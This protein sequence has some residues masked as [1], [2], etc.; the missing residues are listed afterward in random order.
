MRALSD[1]SLL[2]LG[3]RLDEWDFRVLFRGLMNLPGQERRKRYEHVLA[4]IDPEESTT[5][6]PERA[7][8]YMEEYVVHDNVDVY[9]GTVEDFTRELWNRWQRERSMSPPRPAARQGNPFVG[10]RPLAEEALY[11]RDREI[12]RLLD[13]LIADRIVLLYSPSGAGKTSLIQAGLVPRLR[14]DGFTVPPL[15]PVRVGL[16]PRA[17]TPLPPHNRYQLSV[18]LSL[19][20]VLPAK[21]QRSPA[22]LAEMSLKRY[23]QAWPGR[24]GEGRNLVLL[25]D[26]FEELCA[27][28]TTDLSAKAEFMTRLGSVLR[29]PSLWALFAMREE[30]VTMLDPYLARFP[31]RLSSTF[32][33]DFLD[34]QA[35]RVAIQRPVADLGRGITFSDG[36]ATRLV[37]DLRRVRVDRPDGSTRVLG[38]WVEPVQLQVVCRQLWEELPDIDVIDEEHIGAAEDIDKALSRYYEK[39][40]RTVVAKTG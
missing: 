10:P 14:E 20:R 8:R 23:L 25:F 31:T 40:I 26:Q 30:Y 3:F 7:R 18:L 2:F 39:Q 6:E 12:D 33:L 4:Q 15:P 19:E 9:W 17:D 11:G 38:P 22:V 35:A 29:D 1:S 36:A 27:L 21:Q 37:D 32:R 24:G 13:Q 28:D 16:E 5:L 34:Q